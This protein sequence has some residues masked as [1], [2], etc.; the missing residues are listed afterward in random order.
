LEF[1]HAVLKWAYGRGLRIVPVPDA[2]E[3]GHTIVNY[4]GTLWELSAWL[5]GEADFATKPSAAK[6]AAAMA[7]LAQFHLETETFQP[8]LMT[9]ST[10]LEERLGQLAALRGEGV[11]LLLAA[12]R[13][14]EWPALAELAR[15]FLELV[16]PLLD[17]V[18]RQVTAASRIQVPL[19]PCIRDIWHDHILF[20]RDSV[21]GIVDFG[22][23]RIESVAGDVARLMGSLAGD[24][25]RTRAAALEAYESLRPL[26]QAERELLAAFD[27]SATVL[28]GV[29]WVRWIYLEQREF[30]DR[31]RVEQ[32]L[33]VLLQR[34]RYL[35]ASELR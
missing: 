17:P 14:A 2:D 35:A 8:R 34:L 32:R 4:E 5:S 12:I 11:Q 21:T 23:M 25:L 6:L 26:S 13:P 19:Q 22:A 18:S 3:S 20:L 28:G 27:R 30:V 10:G 24:E 16:P 7:A 33:S 9:R 29:N 15:Q 1:I 31:H